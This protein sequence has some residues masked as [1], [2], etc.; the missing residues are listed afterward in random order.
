MKVAP[1]LLLIAATCYQSISMA[2]C[3]ASS[4]QQVTKQFYGWY[5]KSY[6]EGVFPLEDNSPE[7]KRYVSGGLIKSL[8]ETFIR[9]DVMPDDYFFKAQ[10]YFEEWLANM[11][12]SDLE[13]SDT[14][15]RE[16]V[17][18]AKGTEAAQEVFVR[19]AKESGCW[20]VV[21]VEGAPMA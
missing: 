3:S 9:P 2:D 14:A 6:S 1:L 18:L 11:N 16:H 17:E 13:V 4:P 15:A 7:L 19:L 8:H 10:D 21:E 20:K 12:V 5:F